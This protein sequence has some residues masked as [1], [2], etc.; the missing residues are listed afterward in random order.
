MELI[1][2]TWH[3]ETLYSQPCIGFPKYYLLNYKGIVYSEQIKCCHL[4]NETK[5]IGGYLSKAKL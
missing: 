4:V 2:K 5:F 3:S 1:Y